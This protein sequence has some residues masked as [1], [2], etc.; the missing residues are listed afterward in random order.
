MRNRLF[1]IL[2]VVFCLAQPVFLY[3][4]QMFWV[5]PDLII[6]AVVMASIYLDFGWA[7]FIAVLGGATKDIMGLNYFGMNILVLPFYC[8]AIKET[9]R[10]ILLDNDL[11][12]MGILGVIVIFNA[13]LLRLFFML[14][15]VSIELGIF[16][17]TFVFEFLFT[18]FLFFLILQVSN[19]LLNS[20]LRRTIR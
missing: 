15:N 6:I 8:Y 13:L 20:S 10:S 16:L 12:N 18:V 3:S 11:I 9:S 1:F 7:M 14:N 17:R 5:K 19:Y 4:F 2:A